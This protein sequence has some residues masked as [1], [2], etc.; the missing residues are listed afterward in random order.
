[1]VRR[2]PLDTAWSNSATVPKTF[3]CQMSA[4]LGQRHVVGAVDEHVDA[5]EGIGRT[6]GVQ[7]EEAV[8]APRDRGP[9]QATDRVPGRPEG[10]DEDRTQ[11]AAGAGDG[12]DRLPARSRDSCR[13]GGRHRGLP[14]VSLAMRWALAMIVRVNVV[15]GTSGKT[16]ASTRWMWS[17]AARRPVRSVVVAVRARP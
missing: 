9:N 6:G 10:G 3:D 17:H 5:V 7:V 16:D 11:V 15:A 12:D 8:A 2:T 4:L 13:M 14:S 1:M